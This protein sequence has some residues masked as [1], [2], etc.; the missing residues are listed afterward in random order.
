ML[1]TRRQLMLLALALA[2]SLFFV[3]HASAATQ[4]V[5]NPASCNHTDAVV[6][7]GQNCVVPTNICGDWAGGGVAQCYNTGGLAAPGSSAV[8]AVYNG[9]LTAGGYVV[10]CYAVA[11]A[12][13]PY[14]DN[15]GNFWCNSDSSC[16]GQNRTTTCAAGKFAYEVGAFS[17][18]DCKVNY[19]DCDL[20]G[21]TCEINFGVTASSTHANTT[22]A[23]CNTTQCSSGYI[24]C[25]GSGDGSDGD[26]CE[27]QNGGSCTV[28]GLPGSYVG[29]ACTLPKKFFETN[30]EAL[31]ATSG[32]FLWG[33]NYGF[34]DLIK[35][36][37]VSSTDIFTVSND[38]RVYLATTTP[39]GDTSSRLYNVGGDL[40]WNGV[41]IGGAS[42]DS[43]WTDDGAIVRLTT[44]SD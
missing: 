22:Y 13:A 9:A 35:F 7:P 18:G 10:N 8:T 3:S 2:G 21:D 5:T 14:C 38:G 31:Y 24:D 16:Y 41:A 4:W 26:G 25:N 37:N 39:T 6:F 42:G 12:G 15:G 11:D 23:T 44:A 43:G 40:Y 1:R 19:G 34:G 28:S 20:G 30:T 17:C 27:I 32:P 36:G 33:R 29:C